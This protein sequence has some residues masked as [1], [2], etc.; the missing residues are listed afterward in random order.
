MNDTNFVSGGITDESPY[1]LL[2]LEDEHGINTIGGIGHDITAYLDDNQTDIYVLNDFYETER[3]TYKK[4]KV[5]YRLFDIEPGRHT[6]TIKAWDV[7]NNSSVAKIDFQ[8]VSNKEIELEK[9]LNY[10]NPFVDYTEFWFNHNHPF[11]TLDVMLQV[12]SISGKLVWQHRQQIISEGFLSREI[13]WDG[14]DNF[15]HKLAKGVYV[16]KLTVKT[17]T[18][19]TTT[20]VEKLV[21]L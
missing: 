17:L 1:L 10:P 13:S 21:I 14:R 6:L 5:R 15:G 2:H 19:K 18:G 20:K 7:Y 3:N 9:V 16:Y 11:E 12:F 4:G 8:V